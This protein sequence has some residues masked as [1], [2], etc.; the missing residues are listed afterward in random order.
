MTTSNRLG[1]ASVLL[2]VSTVIPPYGNWR[3][4]INFACAVISCVLGLL[5]AHRG[6]KVWLAIPCV[7]VALF[8]VGIVVA[9]QA[10]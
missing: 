6:K 3:G 4:P 9:V 8:V 7:I 2:L 1:L 5:A 10:R